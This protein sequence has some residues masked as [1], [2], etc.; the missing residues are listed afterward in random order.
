[1]QPLHIQTPLIES[2][3]L[4]N[5]LNK[6]VYFKLECVQPPGSFKLRGIGALCQEELQG[7]AKAFVVGQRQRRSLQGGSLLEIGRAACGL[8][9]DESGLGMS[10]ITKRLVRAFPATAQHILRLERIL[11]FRDPAG[12]LAFRIGAYGLLAEGQGAGDHVGTIAPDLNFRWGARLVHL[13][14]PVRKSLL[15]RIVA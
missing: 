5:K 12:R 4:K 15:A 1:M 2:Q 8:G 7:G 14:P 10:A 3:Y 11:V 9:A 13:G 6:H